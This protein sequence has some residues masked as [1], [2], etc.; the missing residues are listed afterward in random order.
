MLLG[1]ILLG[2]CRSYYPV[3]LDQVDRQIKAHD[4]VR[5]RT[6]D[7]QTTKLRVLRIGDNALI[8]KRRSIRLDKILVIEVLRWDPVK[9]GRGWL[10]VGE[11]IGEVIGRA[12]LC[13][14]H[15]CCS[16]R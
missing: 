13:V 12:A 9:A 3:A 16:C 1:L 2:A 11:V 6:T 5:V 4:Q 14:I 10:V 15:C 8:G 7:G